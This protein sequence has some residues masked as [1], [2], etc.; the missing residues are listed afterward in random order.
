[1]TIWRTAAERRLQG[2]VQ[3]AALGFQL[4][5]DVTLLPCARAHPPLVTARG[6]GIGFRL[7][8]YDSDGRWSRA[9]AHG[10]NDEL[11]TPPPPRAAEAEWAE[12]CVYG[13]ILWGHF[14][15]FLLEGLSRAWGIAER[16]DL[17][18]V[19]RRAPARA[20]FT[21]WQREILEILGLGG[22]EHRVVERPVRIRRL[23]VPDQGFMLRRF[24]HPRH[25]AALGV[26]PFRPPVPGR[27]VWLS[28]SGLPEQLA[29][30]AGEAEFE[31]ILAA[32]GWT[33]LHPERLPVR[34]QLRAI[35]DAAAVAGFE[36]S[37]FH[38]LVLGRDIGARVAILGRGRNIL[39]AYAMIGLVKE[40][41]QFGLRVATEPQPA[42]SNQPSSRLLDPAEAATRL[43][44]VLAAP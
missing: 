15:H 43:R 25:A 21:A 6:G 9:L 8:G 28:R 31:A 33:I 12:E 5:E 13:G 40:L 16:P 32:D 38:L 2:I 4:L 41:D 44:D 1:M 19:W 29:R 27:R 14:G 17:P 37:A 34:E 23:W 39:H 11:A 36:G 22:R 18:V 20:E 26:H 42:A 10:R 24:F 3:P 7:G 30:I 35:E